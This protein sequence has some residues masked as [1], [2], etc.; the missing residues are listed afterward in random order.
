[1]GQNNDNH[2]FL[3]YFIYLF[4]FVRATE[5]VGSTSNHLL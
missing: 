2:N 4:Y 5:N 1:M 3:F